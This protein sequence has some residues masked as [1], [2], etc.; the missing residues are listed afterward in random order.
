MLGCAARARGVFP[1][2]RLGL[3]VRRASRA[4]TKVAPPSTTI[5][6]TKSSASTPLLGPLSLLDELPVVVV[7]VWV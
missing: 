1:V 6:A 5:A 3:T 2:R 7:W 4:I